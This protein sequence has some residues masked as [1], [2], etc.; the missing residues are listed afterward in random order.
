MV[1]ARLRWSVS[2]GCSVAVPAG[3]EPGLRFERYRDDNRRDPCS[4]VAAANPRLGITVPVFIPLL[5]SAVARSCLRG[6]AQFRWRMLPAPRE[7]WSALI[8]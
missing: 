7:H 6:I 4:S 3:H 5:V 2:A 1:P 8:C